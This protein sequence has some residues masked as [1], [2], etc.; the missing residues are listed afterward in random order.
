MSH[1]KGCAHQPC[2]SDQIAWLGVSQGDG[3]AQTGIVM[4]EPAATFH[5]AKTK[6][7]HAVRPQQLLSNG[8]MKRAGTGGQP[9]EPLITEF[10]E[11]GEAPK[12]PFKGGGG[13]FGHGSGS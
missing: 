7:R 8:A 12:Q 9:S 4:Q 11:S 13:L 2:P 5:D 1:Y 3:S 6:L 10:T